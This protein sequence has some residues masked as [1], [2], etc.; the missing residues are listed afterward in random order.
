[1]GDLL[2]LG[3]GQY[4]AV[5]KEIAQAMGCFDKISFLDDNSGTKAIGRLSE[6]ERFSG[7][8]EYAIPAIGDADVRLSLLERAEKA[9]YKIP[10]IISPKA[11]VS[12]SAQMGKGTVIEPL[13]GVHANAEIGIAAYI[14]M[15][16][17]VN[18][19]AVVGDG[20]HVDN[21]AVVMSGAEVPSRIK[22][23]P[24]AV[25]KR[26]YNVFNMDGKGGLAIDGAVRNEYNFDVGM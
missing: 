21:N 12:P 9:A 26:R 18:H 23:E 14:S 15:G 22:V 5:V 10:I 4:G 1:M 25:V 8:Y 11:Y 2:I 17:V 19:N 3:A 24:G 6:L 16:A 7:E 20:C 13:A